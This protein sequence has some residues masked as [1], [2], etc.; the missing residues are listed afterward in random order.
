MNRLSIMIIYKSR[1]QN[2]FLFVI[3]IAA[4]LLQGCGDKPKRTNYLARVNDSYLTEEEFMA[5]YDSSLASSPTARHELYQR[6]IRTELL[7]Q[8]ALKEGILEKTDFHYMMERS[9]KELAAALLLKRIGDDQNFDCS[10]EELHSFYAEHKDEFRVNEQSY[11]YN[12]VVCSSE[13]KAEQLRQTSIANGWVA[14]VKA[15]REDKDIG[16]YTNNFKYIYEIETGMM[17][18]LITTMMECETSIVF[19]T[20]PGKYA[21]VYLKNSFS[22]GALPSIDVLRKIISRRVI[23]K[24]KADYIDKYIRD[25]YTGSKID[26]ENPD[27]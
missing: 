17:Q 7:Y 6:W 14:I 5:L 11:L 4:L 19:G 26:M 12:I 2:S 18:R 27:Y 3:F 24:K 9:K 21:F 1:L 16:L 10:D 15:A 13:R 8:K 20:A 22:P 25:L 23:E